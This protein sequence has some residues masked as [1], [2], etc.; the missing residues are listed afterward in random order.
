MKGYTIKD[1]LIHFTIIRRNFKFYMRLSQ[2]LVKKNA[3][4]WAFGKIFQKIM[5]YIASF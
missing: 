5:S 2:K 4:I 1:F 3:H